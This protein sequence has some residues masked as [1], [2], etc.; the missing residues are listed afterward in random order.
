MSLTKQT[1]KQM[2]VINSD[3]RNVSKISQRF[4]VNEEEG[5]FI[6]SE[7]DCDL[8]RGLYYSYYKTIINAP[9]FYTGLQQITNDN[10]TEYGH[11]I[12]TL[13]RFNLYP[14]VFLSLAFRQFKWITNALGWKLERCWTVNRGD[15]SPV[16]SCEGI[17]NPHYFYIDHVFALAGT[18]A[19]WLFVLGTLEALTRSCFFSDSVLG[20]AIAVLAF[21][22]NHGEATRVQWTPPLRESF[23]FPMIIAQI[24]VVTYILK[25]QRY[26]MSYS[27]A[28]AVFGCFSMLFWQFS[29]FALFTQVGSLFAVYAFDYIPRR[30]METLLKGHLITFTVA[31]AMLFGNEMLLTSL[32]MASI[33][34]ALVSVVLDVDPGL[35]NQTCLQVLVTFGSAMEKITVR[36]LYV[37]LTLLCFVIGTIAIKLGVSKLLQVEDDAHIFDILRSKFTDYATF[38]TRLYTCSAEFDFMPFETLQKLCDTW[39][40]PCAGLGILLFVVSFFFVERGRLL[41]RIQEDGKPHGE[42]FYNVVQTAC[43]AMMALLIMRLKLFLTPHLCI[44]SALLANN[45]LLR[46]FKIHL[47][48]RIHTLII[49]VMIAA[50]AYEG[51]SNIEKQ[52]RIKGEYSNPEQE[53]LFDWIQKETKP[54][55]VFA[56]TMPVMANVKL[57]TLRPIVNHPHYEDVGIRNRTKAVYSVFSRKPIGEVHGTL[58]EMGVNYFVFQLFN[59]AFEPKRPYCA[60]R[61][62]WD[63]ADPENI[64]RISNCDLY[65]AAVVHHDEHRILPFKLAYV[66]N[67]NYVVL[68]V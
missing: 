27:L 28:M 34:S 30:T 39:L 14:E 48:K 3:K 50:M 42:V 1:A 57:S 31:Y 58:K 36:P 56:G 38:H 22:F 46:T 23:A 59:C 2:S 44:C 35:T 9:S 26:G 4:R 65:E 8:S 15:L 12:N 53:Q 45:K 21:A 29:Q 11:T 37:S 17:G 13:K 68:Q 47:D 24:A 64:E 43:Y 18:T 67:N 61:G 32:Y 10:V 16:E 51:K 5:K 62:M 7:Y 41:Y 40:I 52:L 60:Y 63:E 49:I 54:D 66:R 33:L 19:G 55:A 25:N 20:G 6:V